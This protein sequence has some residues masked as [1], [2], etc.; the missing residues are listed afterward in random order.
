[1]DYHRLFDLFN[2]QEARYPNEEALAYKRQGQRVAFST[3]ECVHKINQVSAF[4]LRLGLQPG[5]R[6]AIIARHGSPIW[7][8]LDLGMQQIGVIVV[9]LHATSG[10]EEL[11]YILQDAQLRVC[12]TDNADLY[13][14]MRSLQTGSTLE[15]IIPFFP[16][17][18]VNPSVLELLEEP[19]FEELAA[20]EKIREG[21]SK[22]H[23]AT[24]IYTSGTTGH[25]KGVML[26]HQNIISNIKSTI[27]LMP[28]HCEHQALSFLPLSHIFE[29]MVIYTYIAVGAGV[30]YA[31][32]QE[33]LLSNLREVRPHFVTA[34]PLIVERL[35]EQM[36][37]YARKGPLLRRKILQWAIK[38]GKNY[39]DGKRQPPAYWLRLSAAR[40]LVFRRWRKLFGGR[41]EGIV[42]GAAA[43]NPELGR[44]FSAAGLKLR[45]GY[46]L[47]ETS[48][49]IT[50]NRFEPGGARFG[51]VGIPIP[52]VELRIV[53]PDEEGVGEIQ[54]K[55]PNVMLG[56]YNQAAATQQV[57]TTDGWFRTGDVGQWVHKRF[58][59]LKGR[60]DD[61]F[62]TGAGKFIAPEAVEKHLYQSEY[63]QQ[64]LV[65]GASKPAP[66]VLIVPRFERLEEW[67][68]AHKVHWT[69]PQYMVLNPKV[70]RFFKEELERLNQ[71][72]PPYQQVQQFLLLHEP[73][74]E[75]SGEMTATLK[76]RRKR[77]LATHAKNINELY[78]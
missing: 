56:Y 68:H 72:L 38:L 73:W 3:S 41:I 24:I 21:I 51:T 61:M 66:F 71:E 37:T 23:L 42:V 2:Y 34:V 45:E 20:I 60:Q 17:P 55:G 69:A 48:P 7:N 14:V 77:I 35:I 50:F 11:R 46:G 22:N 64:C 44:L 53:D 29:R 59:Q 74:T 6:A 1:M 67:C 36:M 58:L 65:A 16:L 78:P 40:F 13:T 18:E 47:T 5:E 63:I 4:L 10:V 43:L 9:P 15:W 25:P 62:K 70:H 39:Y 27:T 31:E 32:G 8:F 26:S 33:Q 52:G 57:M 19:G 28:V 49:V 12:F 76:L 30:T 54:V 75:Q